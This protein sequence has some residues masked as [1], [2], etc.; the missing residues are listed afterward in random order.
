M[1]LRLNFLGS[2]SRF[3]FFKKYMPKY[4]YVHHKRIAF[5]DNGKTD[6]IEYA[7]FVWHKNNYPKFAQ[8]KVI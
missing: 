5:T 2:I 1:L 7:H 6:S 4:I 3:E 8:L